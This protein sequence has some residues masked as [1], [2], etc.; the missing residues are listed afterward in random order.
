MYSCPF[1]T[2]S[3]LENS[4]L[5]VRVQRHNVYDI[6]QPNYTRF[7][8]DLA[9]LFRHQFRPYPKQSMASTRG[10][11]TLWI[12]QPS[13]EFY[14]RPS[15]YRTTSG[16][17]NS[18]SKSTRFRLSFATLPRPSCV[19]RAREIASFPFLLFFSDFG[20]FARFS[21]LSCSPRW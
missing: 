3:V 9:P 21:R 16:I 19:S 6:T 7:G 13:L 18:I 12:H 20:F 10:P 4:L 14:D 1:H 2:V 8:R 15:Q 17:N 5:L 11:R